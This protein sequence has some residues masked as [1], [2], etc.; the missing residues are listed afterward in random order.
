M[1]LS[2]TV[3]FIGLGAAAATA[4]AGGLLLP[5]AG[6]I[7]T[8]RA[9]AAI[10][11]ADDAEAITLN[12]AG[13]A[14]S[15][16][17]H[18]TIGADA[19]SY[20]MSFKR[21]GDYPAIMEEATT[22]AGTPYPIMT[23]QAKPAL[24]IGSFQPVPLIGI[25]SDLNGLIP[26]LH[27]GFSVYAP[28]AYPFRNLNNVNGQPYYFKDPSTGAFS[29]PSFGNAPPPTRYD[30][31]DQSATIILP[32]I[33]AAYSILPNL[34][35]GARFSAGF[36]QL[37]STVAVWGLTN[38]EE[39]PKQDGL[40]TI[41][42]T[43]DFVT[44]YGFGATYRPTPNIELAA[45]WSAPINVHASGTAYSSNGP[46]VTLNGNS[47]SVTPKPDA[48]TNCAK[49]GT[50]AALKACVDVEAAPMTATIG[51]RWKFLDHQ[52]KMRGDVELNLGWEHWGAGCD[53][54]NGI[55]N[56]LDPSDYH[57]TIDG[58][59]TSPLAPGVALPLQEQLIEHGFQDT[60]S[61]RLGGSWI[62]PIV[63][64]DS[65]VAR[66]GVS[67]DSAAAKDGWERLD[68]DGA[69]RTMMSIGASYKLERFSID[70]G[71]AYV[72]EGTR[73]QNR[74]CVPTSP[75][76]GCGPGGAPETFQQQTG[77]NP[78]NPVFQFNGQ[79]EDPVD[80]GSIN[81]HYVILML[82]ASTWF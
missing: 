29:F 41:H 50:A 18:V 53:Y 64:N 79:L 28:N 20:A 43:D 15:K 39:N 57:V 13:I 55:G 24:G 8:S 37:Q 82:G 7:S 80:Q 44:T 42:A 63:G 35:I 56:C 22:F 70:A 10:A 38:Y 71:F 16:G 66:A 3:V 54:S 46:D 9:G 58:Q 40:V 32:S 49:G 33:A 51:G 21:A 59:V 11:S 27:V 62:F 23:N 6:V 1:K 31:I 34:D 75:T 12:P 45:Q 36:A 61:A 67:Y 69:A 47:V 25:T 73:N 4:H 72:Y 52:G 74:N 78:V 60:Y 76:Q 2:G 77:T 19:I 81:S 5:G 14:K 68:V 26:K 65:I 48:M 17:T 30:I